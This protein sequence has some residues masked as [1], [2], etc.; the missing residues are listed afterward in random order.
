M[1][2]RLSGI[3]LWTR[4]TRLRNGFG[5]TERSSCGV[6]AEPDRELRPH[7]H[8]QGIADW[9][10]QSSWPLDYGLLWFRTGLDPSTKTEVT[11]RNLQNKKMGV[12]FFILSAEPGLISSL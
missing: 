11:L 4:W 1:M 10:L 7:A 3:H 9:P 8:I 2:L 6:L 12:D 5:G